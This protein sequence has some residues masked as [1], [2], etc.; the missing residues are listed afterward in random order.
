MFA[1]QEVVKVVV[2]AGRR[3]E[4]HLVRLLPHLPPIRLLVL[5]GCFLRRRRRLGRLAICPVFPTLHSTTQDIEDRPV[6]LVG[7]GGGGFAT[8]PTPNDP[9][10]FFRD[11]T[12]AAPEGPTAENEVPVA[13]RIRRNVV[14]RAE[15]R[16]AED[17]TRAAA[18]ADVDS[19]TVGQEREVVGLRRGTSVALEGRVV[20]VAGLP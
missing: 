4:K 17:R 16:R 1:Q 18:A 20:S 14:D 9:V 8:L 13:V 7:S 5:A 2:I 6:V 19:S 10:L 3:R 15:V 11:I 12:A